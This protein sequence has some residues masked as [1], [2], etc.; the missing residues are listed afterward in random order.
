MDEYISAYSRPLPPPLT[1]A[2]AALAFLLFP[3]PIEDALAVGALLAVQKGGHV[4]C[5]DNSLARV[6]RGSGREDYADN[7]GDVCLLEASTAILWWGMG[8]EV[9]LLRSWGRRKS[10]GLHNSGPAARGL[11]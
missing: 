5:G 2:V 8:R 6:R 10:Q 3:D 11:P 1:N 4:Q 7:G 9:A